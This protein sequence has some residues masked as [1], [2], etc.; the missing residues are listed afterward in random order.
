MDKCIDLS[1][2]HLD[3]L[4]VSKPGVGKNFVKILIFISFR[5][6]GHFWMP[7]LECFM[8]KG[9]K[10]FGLVKFPLQTIWTDNISTV[11][12]LDW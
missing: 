2:H 5:D 3:R 9:Y 8:H 6:L 12:Y 10:L 7:L 11:N 1:P 4:S